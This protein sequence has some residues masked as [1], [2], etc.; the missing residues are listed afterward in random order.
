MTVWPGDP[1]MPGVEADH[2]LADMAKK[3][4]TEARHMFDR[5]A[6]AWPGAPM[7]LASAALFGARRPFANLLFR[8]DARLTES[9]DFAMR[10]AASSPA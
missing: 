2:S 3:A 7:A 9:D 6:L 1:L 10:T 8:N 4:P 5:S